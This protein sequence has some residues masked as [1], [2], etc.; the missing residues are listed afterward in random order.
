LGFNVQVDSQHSELL[1][2]HRRTK[3]IKKRILTMNALD[4][5]AQAKPNSHQADLLSPNKAN[6]AAQLHSLFSP[7][8]VHPYQDAWIEI[9]YSHPATGN[10][11]DAQ[12]FSAFN[13]Q[14]AVEFA[15]AKN[16]AGFNVYV[17]PALRQGKQPRTGRA[18]DNNFLASAYAWAEFDG[19]GDDERIETILKEKQLSPAM[20]VTTG[21]VPHRRAHL[22]FKLDDNA[23]AETLRAIN[24]SLCKL[25]DSDAVQS[26]SHVMRLAGTVNYPT[27]KKQKRRY[28]AEL[29]TL[30]QREPRAYQ[31]GALIE[32]SSVA[33]NPFIEYGKSFTSGRSDDE[34]QALLDASRIDGKWHDSMRDAIAIMIGRGWS[35][36]AIRLICGP[37]CNSGAADP[38]LVPLIDGGRAKWDKPDTEGKPAAPH[39]A[40]P[41]IVSSAD[42]LAGFVPP[43]Y[44]IDGILQRHFLY[45]M[46]APT[47]SGKTAIALTIAAHVA[48]GR[49]IGEMFVEKGRVLYLA[50]ENPDDIRM[51]WL[52][53]ADRLEFDHATIDVHFLPGVFKLSEIKARIH[54]EISKIGPFAL[55][56]I[57]TSAAYYEGDDE[58]ANVQ[59]GVHARRLRELVT[60]PGEPCVLVACHPTKAAGTDNLLPRGGG[61]FIAEVDGNLTCTKNESVVKVHYQ[62][63]FRGPDFAPIAF[64]LHTATADA[65]KDSKG[66]PI[67]TVIALPLSE[68]E[69]QQAELGSRNDE[70]DLLAVMADGHRRSMAELATALHWLTK[71]RKPYKARVQRAGD[72]LKASKMATIE[73]GGLVLTPKGEKEAHRIG[74]FSAIRS[75]TTPKF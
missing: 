6:I 71:D 23:N 35:D 57:D 38:D 58:N 63:K 65:L 49:G 62:G 24:T 32:L 31:A 17:G 43:D 60:L 2:Q 69:Q 59:M 28:V 9:A 21:N 14:E 68:N 15:A 55:V 25:F 10:L 33:T 50:G 45:S 26:P 67:P 5:T 61:A 18:T 11:N 74:G 40:G 53:S 70:D 47:G 42:F 30:H 41:L 3:K 19:A 75:D 64:Q 54:D 46:T 1:D 29:V 27:L 51:R 72:R 8:F 4:T 7:A 16:A 20:I 44:L 56:V 22:Y 37:Y 36:S 34:L 73:R 52:A 39:P 48:L 13:L 12:N 66:R